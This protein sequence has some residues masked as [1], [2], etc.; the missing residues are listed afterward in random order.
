VTGDADPD[1][2]VYI[3]RCGDNSLYAGVAKDV[4]KRFAEHQSN[5]SKCAKYLKGRGPL[6]LVYQEVVGTKS[7]ALKCEYAVKQ[8]SKM[9]KE[10]LVSNGFSLKI[11]K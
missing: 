10:R 3:V 9:A 7:A 8:L 2:S 11:E 6:V 1:W 4:G 5:G